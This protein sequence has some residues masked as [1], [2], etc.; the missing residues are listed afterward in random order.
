MRSNNDFVVLLIFSI[1]GLVATTIFSSVI[2]SQNKYLKFTLENN[3][4]K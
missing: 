1:F 3:E 2:L 4:K